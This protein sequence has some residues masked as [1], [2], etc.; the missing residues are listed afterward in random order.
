MIQI[1]HNPRC[2][3]SRDCLT[4]LEQS[5]KEFQVIKYLET[6][7][8]IEELKVIIEKLNIKPIE[9]VRQK[10]KVWIENF[11]NSTMTDEEIILAMVANPIL[12]ERPIV[13]DGKK[14]VIARPL[15]K[16]NTIL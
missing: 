4:Y 11:K 16:M 6:V 2:G 14:A 8:T 7:P 10:E 15:E 9:L 1:Y 12:I 13:I 3:K 5:G